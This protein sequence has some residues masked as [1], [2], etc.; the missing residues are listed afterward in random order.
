MRVNLPV[1][2]RNHDYPDDE[3]LVSITDVQG[4]I[5]HC[6]RAFVETSGFSYDELMG[7]PHNLIRH[8]DM[9][10]AAFKDMWATIGRGRP[11][12]GIVKNRR[13][14]GDH[15]WVQANA[16]PIM[17]QGRPVSY[18]SVRFK[19]TQDEVRAAESLYAR[20]L[21]EEV[22]GVQT[23]KLHAGRVRRLGWRDLPARLHRTTLTQRLG[24]ALFSMIILGMLPEF[25]GVESPVRKWWQLGGLLAGAAAA[26]WWFD[27]RLNASIRIA[28]QL[29]TDVAGCNLSRPVR[30]RDNMALESVLRPMMQVHT[31]LRAVMGDAREEVDAFILATGR[32]A[33][34]A[35][36]LSARTESQ[37]SSL[38]QTA[39]SMEQL[40]GTVR[41]TADAAAEVSDS[42]AQASAAV[43]RSS[44]AV[45]AVG[46][47]IRDMAQ[48]SQR[49]GDIVHLIEGIAFQTNI[50]AL[51]AAV[52]AARAGEQGRGFAVVASE[53][54]SL[55]Q[56]S[57]AAAKEIKALIGNSAEQVK[58]GA[59][60]AQ[61]AGSTMQEV[62][63]S[64]QRVSAV[65]EE[66]SQASRE[67][68]DG[69]EQINEAVAQMDQ[70]TQ[71]NAALVEQATA[72]AAALQQQAHE[73][74][75]VVAAFRLHEGGHESGHGAGHDSAPAALPAAKAPRQLR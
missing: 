73:L 30:L 61:Q 17:D 41:Q 31:N 52:E 45:G 18:M 66:I 34:G 62:V 13:K 16:M 63:N 47:T 28:E 75:Q 72:A 7:Q 29:V 14:N 68:T 20:L 60:L 12:S 6:N 36:E 26:L 21:A 35:Q 1:T 8:P 49:I 2:Q 3:M 43:Q 58:A 5:T 32:I 22:S 27:S 59:D 11:W 70:S 55:A 48:A 37:A 74:N 9:P 33:Q 25:A 40:S 15:Y 65:I 50:L 54:R 46:G 44:A 24:V 64:V 69:I 53:V 67:Q 42:S 10:A 57:S 51:N 19:P 23:F 71:Q 38:Q 56:R 4:R 39:A